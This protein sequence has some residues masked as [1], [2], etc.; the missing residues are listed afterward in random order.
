IYGEVYE[1]KIEVKSI[2]G[3]SAHAGQSFLLE[4]ALRQKGRVKEVFLVHGEDR[5]AEPLMEL[6]KQNGMPNVH[7]PNRGQV[8][9]V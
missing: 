2:Q 6:M 8:F 1:P 4:Y 5:G 9:T 3:F 7:Y